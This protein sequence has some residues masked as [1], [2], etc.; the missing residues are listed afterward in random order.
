MK[1]LISTDKTQ[2]KRKN[3]Y[4]WVPLGEL[5][6]FAFECDGGSVDDSCGCKRAMSGVKSHKATTTFEVADLPMTKEELIKTLE[7]SLVGGGWYDAPEKATKHATEDAN[8]IIRLSATFPVGAVLEKRGN[9][10]QS[11]TVSSTPKPEPKPKPKVQKQTKEEFIEYL[12]ETL[13]PDLKRD[14]YEGFLHDF[15]TALG[16]L[17]AKPPK[18]ARKSRTTEVLES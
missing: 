9:Q 1:V 15:E 18:R 7:V 5:V 16:F 2:G 12:K 14:G 13:I 4:C 3:D 17:E 6:S 10:I 8:E 11:R